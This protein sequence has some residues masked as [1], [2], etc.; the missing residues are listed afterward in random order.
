MRIRHV[1]DPHLATKAGL[2]DKPG[3]TCLWGILAGLLTA[4]A[5]GLA[6][7]SVLT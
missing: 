3:R 5:S 2:S 7:L 4:Y 1:A 6:V